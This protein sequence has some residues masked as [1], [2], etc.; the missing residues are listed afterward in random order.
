LTQAG[1]SRRTPANRIVRN[2]FEIPSEKGGIDVSYDEILES[3]V[4][5]C[6]PST[7]YRWTV[8]RDSMMY[9]QRA[10]GDPTLE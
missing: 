10:E 1:R 5:P 4:G 7:H 8:S 3:S 9:E 6:K 2:D